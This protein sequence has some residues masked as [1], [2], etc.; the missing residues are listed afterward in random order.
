MLPV[1]FAKRFLRPIR[2]KPFFLL[3]LMLFFLSC[4]TRTDKI[5]V[6]SFDD[7]QLCI[8][9]RY[10]D[11]GRISRSEY[12]SVPFSFVVKNRGTENLV[13]HKVEPSCPCVKINH[14]PN[15]VLS[16]EHASISGKIGLSESDGTL[17]KTIFLTYN[18]MKVVLLKVKG[19][20][21]Q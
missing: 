5:G 10:Y 19:I 21:E 7:G 1:L 6:D 11:F 18:D 3:M 17:S 13:I 4:N 8:E 2:F 20:V 14:V 16:A 15:T 9:R 12:D